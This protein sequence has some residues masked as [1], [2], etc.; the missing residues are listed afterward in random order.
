MNLGILQ[1]WEANAGNIRSRA[2]LVLFRLAQRFYRLP[3]AWRWLGF[4]YLAFYEVFI[5]WGLGI[6]LNHKAAIGP[7]LKLYHGTALVIHGGSVIG[8]HC[9]LRHCTTIGMK[10]LPDETPVIGDHVDIGCNSVIIGKIHVGDRAVIG[11]G[12]VVVKDVPAGAVAA[13]NPARVIR[14]A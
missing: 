8:A 9:T 1:D 5:G 7:S 3:A 6:E 11:A 4:P 13:G 14:M 10:N 2:I 12:S